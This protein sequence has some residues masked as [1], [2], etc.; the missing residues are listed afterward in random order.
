MRQNRIVPVST[1]WMFFGGGSAWRNWIGAGAILLASCGAVAQPIAVGGQ[2]A[3][4]QAGVQADPAVVRYDG[5]KVIRATVRDQRDM[6]ALTTLGESIWSHHL[7]PDGSIDVQ[8]R[9][10][11]L[12]ALADLGITYVV[13]IDDVQKMV[14]DERRLMAELRSREDTT[15]YQTFR[16]LD[17][18]NARVDLLAATYPQFVQ[19]FTIPNA[20]VEGRSMKGFRFTSPDKPGNPAGARP[21]M[22]FFG[23]EHAREWISPMTVMFIGEHMLERYATDARIRAVV[24][25]VETIVLPVMNVDGYLYSWSNERL[26]RKNRRNNGGGTFG[27]DNNRNWGYQ[28]GGEGASSAPSNDTYRGPSAF[29]EPETRAVR[30]FIIGNPRIAASIDYHS[31][32]LLILSPWSYTATLPPDAALFDRVNSLIQTDIAS[33]YGQVYDAGPTYTTIYPASGASLDW[34]YGAQNKMGLSIELRGTSFSPPPSEI[35]PC[36]EENLRGALALGEFIGLP[37]RATWADGAAPEVLMAN[38]VNPVRVNIENFSSSLAPGGGLLW[39]NIDGLGWVASPLTLVSGTTY[40]GKLPAAGCGRPLEFYVEATAVDGRRVLLP[41]GGGDEPASAVYRR[42]YRP[43]DD[44]CEVN[45]GWSLT[46]ASDTATTGRWS[47]ANPQRTNYQPEDDHTTAGV[48]CFV[49]DGRVGA[50]DGT[51]DVDNGVTTLTSPRFDMS[52]PNANANVLSATISYWRWFSTSGA[53][54]FQ[55]QISNNDGATWTTLEQVSNQGNAWRNFTTQVA[56]VITPTPNMRL[57][58]IA[59]DQLATLVEA[60]VDDVRAEIL[61]CPINPADLNDDGSIEFGDFLEF[62]NGFDALDPRVDLTGEGDVEF[63]DFLMFFNLFD[64]G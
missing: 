2:I 47:L 51:Y 60:A 6:L 13:T 41:S 58:F 28:W 22:F 44:P 33:V 8:I 46:L 57:R 29:S 37:L 42:V 36:G 39:S 54:V 48:N 50:G 38:S 15:W 45:S 16:T 25:N 7:G 27:V 55:V 52:A 21:A 14:D 59:K 64:Q 5:Q 43:I 40:E 56:G 10:D 11:R 4:A 34:V 32:A 26:W 30:D 19:T 53:E 20:T 12:D 31:Y 3:D 35:I 62:F 63:G 1:G 24:D 9:G 17:E 18:I 61:A 23:A 49:T